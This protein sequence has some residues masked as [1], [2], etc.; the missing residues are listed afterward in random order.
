M[1]IGAAITAGSIGFG[2]GS[3]VVTDGAAV[4]ATTAP[5]VT[6]TLLGTGLMADAMKDL[7]EALFGP[8]HMSNNASTG[9]VD[10][11]KANKTEHI[12]GD[13]LSKHK[14]GDFLKSFQGDKVSAYDALSQAAKDYAKTNGI[15]AGNPFQSVMNVNGFNVTVRGYVNSVTDVR[16]STA[17]IP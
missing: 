12:F 4:P 5:A 1:T 11:D 7:K 15:L 2:L 17:Y 3:D 14:L 9:Q 13:N 6:G 8:S 10:T 16:V